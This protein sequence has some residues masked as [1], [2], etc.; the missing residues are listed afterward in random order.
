MGVSIRSHSWG[1]WIFRFLLRQSPLSGTT[2]VR[3]FFKIQADNVSSI[4]DF[5]S[6]EVRVGCTFET[7]TA[8]NSDVTLFHPFMLFAWFQIFAATAPRGT[9]SNLTAWKIELL[10][11]VTEP[12]TCEPSTAYSSPSAGRNRSGLAFMS[13]RQPHRPMRRR[14]LSRSVPAP[15]TPLHL[16][17]LLRYGF[18][19]SRPG[20]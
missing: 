15:A 20:W 9:S 8:L 4:K 5:V 11:S 1:T 10:Q 7:T 19:L 14:N 13:A 3:S 12:S 2:S 17:I 16:G 6:T 18:P